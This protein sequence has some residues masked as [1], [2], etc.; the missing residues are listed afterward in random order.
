MAFNSAGGFAQGF[1]DAFLKS[2]NAAIRQQYYEWMEARADRVDKENQRRYDLDHGGGGGNAL[3]KRMTAGYDKSIASQGGDSRAQ[4]QQEKSNSGASLSGKGEGNAT[5]ML[6][7]NELV[8]R[9]VDPAVA[10]GAVGS[11][12]GE[13][14]GKMDPNARNKGDGADGSDSVGLGQWNGD[15]AQNLYK[16]AGTTDLS[17]IPADTQAKFFGWELDHT[18]AGQNTLAQLKGAEPGNVQAGNY[19]WTSSFEVP[20]DISGQIKVR[21]PYGDNF[22]KWYQ[23]QQ[24]QAASTPAT[25]PSGA[26]ELQNYK[27]RPAIPV[28]TDAQGNSLNPDGSRVPNAPIP[29][30]TDASAP[31]LPPVRP[32]DG[33]YAPTPQSQPQE[34]PQD[35][36]QAIPDDYSNAVFAGMRGGKVKRYADGGSVAATP[37]TTPPPIPSDYG[38]S[39]V[40]PNTGITNYSVTSFDNAGNASTSSIPPPPQMGDLTNM[41]RG[42]VPQVY[43][44]YGKALGTYYQQYPTANPTYTPAVSSV[45]YVNPAGIAAPTIGGAPPAMPQGIPVTASPQITPQVTPQVTPNVQ[46]TPQVGVGH[47][48][49]RGGGVKRYAAGGDVDA[50]ADD[51]QMQQDSARMG[52]IALSDSSNTNAP[53]ADP[54]EVGNF[55]AN[56]DQLA[57]NMRMPSS[58]GSGQLPMPRGGAG[59][60]LSNP[61]AGATKPGAIGDFRVNSEI[62]IQPDTPPPGMEAVPAIRDT[63]GNISQGG[64]AAL[65]DGIKYLVGNIGKAMGMPDET[66]ST[67]Q[68]NA[69]PGGAAAMSPQEFKQLH[70]TV[71]PKGTLSD[72]VA[73]IA[74]MEAGRQYYLENGE[75]QKAQQMAASIILRSQAISMEHGKE[76]VDRLYKGD[77][78]GAIKALVKSH[79]IVP[80]GTT[81]DIEKLKTSPGDQ[82]QWKVTQKNIDGVELWQQT[83]GPSEILKYAIGASDGSEAMKRMGE[84]A[85]TYNPKPAVAPNDPDLAKHLDSL[86]PSVPMT[87]SPESAPN[88]GQGRPQ[89]VPATPVAGA[90][91]NPTPGAPQPLVGATPSTPAGAT[92]APIPVNGQPVTAAQTAPPQGIPTMPTRPVTPTPPTAVADTQDPNAPS[93]DTQEA[94]LA[95]TYGIPKSDKEAVKSFAEQAA[96]IKPRYDAMQAQFTDPRKK[97][98]SPA[99]VRYFQSLNKGDQAIYTHDLN[100]KSAA[101]KTQ[102]QVITQQYN[103]ELSDVATGLRQGR[104]AEASDARQQ[105]GFAQRDK[106]AADLEANKQANAATAATVAQQRDAAKEIF[107]KPI[108]E[109]H[110]TDTETAIGPAFS[111]GQDTATANASFGTNF[112]PS[113]QGKLKTMAARMLA[114]N[115]DIDAPTAASWTA[116]A[117]LKPESIVITPR[118]NSG[119][120]SDMS[121]KPAP[122]DGSP[123]PYAKARTVLTPVVVRSSYGSAF[124]AIHN[125]LSDK[126]SKA[127]E[128][129]QKT[130]DLNSAR[131]LAL[132]ANPWQWQPKPG[133]SWMPPASTVQKQGY[134]TQAIPTQ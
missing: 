109:Q 18:H 113:T 59:A 12:M 94:Q 72:G 45:G 52:D 82:P 92:V 77:S 41:T 55:R 35:Q 47:G 64:A 127:G 75:L 44:D 1:I 38:S 65:S 89:A 14:G 74:A 61:S 6:I 104:S 2:R 63:N 78:D 81:A 24:T 43:G 97:A 60:H 49:S 22:H 87:N 11:A 31:P 15:R 33:D 107:N 112:T 42:S 58:G 84:A 16:F 99:E 96:A 19:I 71:D 23:D 7:H 119:G 40:D 114:D 9:G 124:K 93:K 117:I 26:Q 111:P 21:Q 98:D 67:A 106:A 122:T 100:A 25:P 101:Y 4:F 95:L 30:P 132:K 13:S 36:A 56:S 48:Y 37:A 102:M 76:A 27:V 134:T 80:D 128:D 88:S 68:Q 116:Q 110:K 8:S 46:V 120:L 62:P 29:A 108:T 50:G 118:P 103:K 10:S 83:V 133:F 53:T 86:D 51:Y 54:N 28:S 5:G 57:M 121:L 129:T 32:T 34:V 73:T 79:N 3:T 39:S 17:K 66:K 130:K 69:T 115:D 85:G 131:D 91:P 20:A 125:E 90:P 123:D 105:A 70:Q 126:L